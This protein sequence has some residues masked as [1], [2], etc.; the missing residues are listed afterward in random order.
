MA[1]S[2]V[3]GFTQASGIE[4]YRAIVWAKMTP[5]LGSATGPR[6]SRPLIPEAAATTVAAEIWA[7]KPLLLSHCP[8]PACPPL[9]LHP[10]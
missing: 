5:A 9:W 10:F 3:T 6:V 8:L 2:S 7:A 4:S 1:P